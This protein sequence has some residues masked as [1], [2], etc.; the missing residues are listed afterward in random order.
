MKTRSKK[1]NK[2]KDIYPDKASLSNREALELA[3]ANGVKMTKA[4]LIYWNKKYKLAKKVFGRW[5][6]NKERLLLLL[7][8]REDVLNGN[9]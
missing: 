5:E 4:G 1:S 6:V 8:S 9:I 7:K 3:E 2:I